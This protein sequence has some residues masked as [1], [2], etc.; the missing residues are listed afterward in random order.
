[1]I[2]NFST[3][4]E[5]T[6]KEVGGKALSL[7]EATKAGFKVPDG[8]VLPVD[9]FTPWLSEIKA[10]SNW[11]EF[12]K[13]PT[14]AECDGLKNIRKSLKLNSEQNEA[15]KKALRAVLDSP[16][17]AVRSSSPEED[18]EGTSFA[19]LYETTLGV[20]ADKIENAIINSFIS[21]FDIRIVE[22]KKLNNISIDEPN[23]AVI[24]Q[25][26]IKSD[27]SGIAFSLNPQNNA[28]DEAVINANFGL[29]E[30]VVSGVVTPDTYIVDKVKGK[31]LEKKIAEKSHA[32]FLKNDGGTIKQDNENPN[33]QA[34]SDKQILIVAALAAKCEEYYKRPMDIEWAIENEKLYLLQSRPITTYFEFFDDLITKPG[35]EKYLYMDLI[36]VSQGIQEELS[37][38]GLDI[39]TEVLKVAKQGTTPIGMDGAIVNAHGRQYMHMSNMLKGLGEFAIRK[40]IK[41]YDTATGKIME[42]VNLKKEYMPAVKTKKIKKMVRD[43]VKLGLSMIPI[44]L[45]SQSNHTKLMENYAKKSDKI[46]GYC[47]QE[48]AKDKYFNELTEEGVSAFETMVRDATSLLAGMMANSKIKKMFKNRDVD[49]YLVG[50]SMDLPG[51]PTSEM[52]H[53]ILKLASYNEIQKT[54]SKDEFLRNIEKRAYSKE[55]LEDYDYYMERYGCRGFKEIDIASP[56]VYENPMDFFIQLD[57][58]NIEENAI[59]TVRERREKAYGELLKI[60]KDKGFEKK[61]IKQEKIHHDMMGYR[62][63]PKFIYIVVV[64]M[65][66]KRALK[67]GEKFK[68]QSRL[69][70]VNQIF[71]LHL[72]QVVC[73][74]KDEKFQLFPLIEENL[75]P[76][77]KV[78][79][80]KEW[81]KI[82]DSRGKIFMPIRK[83][84]KGDMVGDPIA[85]GIVKGRAKVLNSPY[86]KPI[87]KGDILVT[88]STEPSWTPIFINATGIVLEVG[89]QLQHGAII[90]R[91]YG[92]PCVSGLYDATKLIKDGDML[93]VDG[94]SGIV[95][96]IN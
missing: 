64:D 30:T 89:G 58:I 22:Y 67:L 19:G 7:I 17:F 77:R 63:L 31:I 59:S 13:S 2:H 78:K 10:S 14:K 79:N 68:K 54:K 23:I 9:F 28:Y 27:V 33:A 36:L 5:L 8:F 47:K 3:K 71:D 15:L 88:I 95:K 75:V 62:E 56:R 25:K 21:V 49:D 72:E 37:T 73:A 57:N 1:M 76:R 96:I 80:V 48:L 94:S 29:G 82:L 61:F 34:I 90:A 65:L 60:A 83:S 26:Q 44:V 93:E 24:I 53:A 81:P 45:K 12:L 55:F 4:T 39:W 66:R 40:M 38:L 18:L 6:L 42:S 16:T 20:K 74:E 87:E 41:T 46:Y 11:K 85:P 35:E 92:I 86:E 69:K 91:E 70:D 32:L 51:N 50:L 84:A 52:G 43:S